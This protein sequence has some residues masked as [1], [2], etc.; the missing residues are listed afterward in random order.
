MIWLWHRVQGCGKVGVLTHHCPLLHSQN[1]QLRKGEER[2]GIPSPVW[3]LFACYSGEVAR[4][5]LVQVA[6]YTGVSLASPQDACV[7]MFPVPGKI[8]VLHHLMPVK[9]SQLLGSSEMF[10]P[11]LFGGSSRLKLLLPFHW[12]AWT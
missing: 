2:W 10:E 7:L 5:S 9:H 3:A 11:F 1:L 6:A 4:T 8:S 12:G